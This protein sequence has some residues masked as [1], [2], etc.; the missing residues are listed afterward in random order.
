MTENVGTTDSKAIYGFFL[1]FNGTSAVKVLS[2]GEQG[3]EKQVRWME[4]LQVV[5][6]KPWCV[7]E[8]HL[9]SA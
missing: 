4:K 1:D 5:V 2:Q 6:E 7:E 3:K 9:L 8:K